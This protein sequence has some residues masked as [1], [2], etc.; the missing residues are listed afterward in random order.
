MCFCAHLPKAAEPPALLIRATI[1]PRTTRKIKI[2][3]VPETAPISPSLTRI[4]IV[5]VNLKSEPRIEPARIP[6][7]NEL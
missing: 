3:A 2:P 7:N 1:A 4:S 5:L 6:T